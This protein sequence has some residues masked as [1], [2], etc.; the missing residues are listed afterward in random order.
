MVIGRHGNHSPYPGGY[1]V[2]TTNLEVLQ[3]VTHVFRELELH[4][5]ICLMEYKAKHRRNNKKK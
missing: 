3:R 4:R 1:P 2:A 5:T